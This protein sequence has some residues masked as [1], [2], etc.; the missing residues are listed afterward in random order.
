ML[1]IDILTIFPDVFDSYFAASIISRAQK[2]HLLS[3]QAH[4]LRRWAAGKHRK[5]DDSPY[6]GGPGMVL[7]AEPI[8][9]AL[10]SLR[11]L[12]RSHRQKSAPRIILTSARGKQFTAAD[13]KRLAKYKR[14]IFICGRYEGVDERVIEQFA[15]EEL[16]IG[17][18]ILTGGELPAMAM[19]D[20]VARHIPG[21]LGKSE[22]LEETRG[23]FPQYTRPET[24]AWKK[25]K[26]SVPKVLLSGDHQKIE[27]WRKKR[28]K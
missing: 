14:L 16:S 17:P 27:A 19:S 2:K 25:E 26:L 28:S 18:Y 21:V 23:S 7:K 1:K 22:S 10:Q 13:A 9:R 11:A 15:D 6:G 24:F 8:A 12:P 4:D 5:V 3:I 20:A